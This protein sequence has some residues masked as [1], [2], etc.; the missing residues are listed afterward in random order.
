M[1]TVA[2]AGSRSGVDKHRRRAVE[3]SPRSVH[4]RESQYALYLSSERVQ[5]VSPQSLLAEGLGRRR[6]CPWNVDFT[7]MVCDGGVTNNG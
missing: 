7:E 2:E 5:V 3:M 4:A 6:K 1:Q